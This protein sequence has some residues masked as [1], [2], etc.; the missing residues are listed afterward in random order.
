MSDSKS[1][2]VAQSGTTNSGQELSD[3]STLAAA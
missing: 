3:N 1:M 2:T